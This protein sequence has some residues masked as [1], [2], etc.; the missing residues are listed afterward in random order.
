MSETKAERLKAANEKLAEAETAWYKAYR[1]QA[2]ATRV[3]YEA[4]RTAV[5]I[6]DEP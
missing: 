1:A 3:W 5:D 2:E 4:L 6:E